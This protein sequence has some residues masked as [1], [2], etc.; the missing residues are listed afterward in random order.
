[1]LLEERLLISD[2]AQVEK[3]LNALSSRAKLRILRIL[4]EKGGATAKEVAEELGVKI[5]TVLE[6]LQELVA[7]GV[8]AVDEVA[9]GGR[10]AKVYRLRARR[11]VI[12][13]DLAS[14][15]EKERRVL[16]ELLK[17]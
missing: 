15:T 7:A 17:R 10:R 4:Y 1:M 11:I 6:H 16:E 13:V 8:V 14:Y 5:P 2:A 3:V 9:R 12:E